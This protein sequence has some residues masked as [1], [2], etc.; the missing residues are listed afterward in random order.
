MSTVNSQIVD[1]VSDVVTLATGTAPAQAFGMLDTVMVE[2]LGMAM[3]NAVNRQQGA[4]MIGSAAVTAA[5]A[6]MIN[7]H[8]P[9]PGLA[10]PPLPEPPHV[11]PLRPQPP[12]PTGDFAQ[13]ASALAG[14]QSAIYTLK[15]EAIDPDSPAAGLAACGL[16]QISAETTPPSEYG[17]VAN[18]FAAAEQAI[19][20]LKQEAAGTDAA[21]S[22]LAQSSLARI[23]LDAKVVPSTPPAGDVTDSSAGTVPTVTAPT[24]KSPGRKAP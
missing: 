21:V 3:Y 14:A 4:S 23:A 5:C 16:S 2:T 12:S 19:A 10:P 11:D 18:A 15:E 9:S 13:V 17:G 22:A 20:A 24:T 1:S 6:K 7:A 8:L